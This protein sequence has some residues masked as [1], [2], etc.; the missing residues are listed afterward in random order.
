MEE[1]ALETGVA[2]GKGGIGAFVAGHL[3][4]LLSDFRPGFSRVPGGDEHLVVGGG[5]GV[6]AGHGDGFEGL[7]VLLGVRVRW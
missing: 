5:E 7:F 1:G 4:P 3:F 2:V 6:G